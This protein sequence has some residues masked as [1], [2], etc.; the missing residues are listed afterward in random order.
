MRIAP[1]WQTLSAHAAR[2]CESRLADLIGADDARARDFSVRVGAL[3]GNFS[4]QRYDR[5]AHAA[6]VGMANEAGVPAALRALFEGEPV[7]R[8]EHRAALH[9]ALRSD[10][11]RSEAARSAQAQ[12]REA[13]ARMSALVAALESSDVTDVINIGIGGSDLGPRLAVDALGEFGTGRFRLH[14]LNNADGHPLQRLLRELDPA[15]TAVVLVSKSF[16]TQ[17]TLL[18]GNALKRWLRREDVLYAVTASPAKAEAFGVAAERILPMWDW[19]GGRY[20]LW[21]SVSLVCEIALTH[22]IFFRML[23]GAEEMDNHFRDTPFAQNLPAISAAVQMWN[24]EALGHGSYAMIPYSERLR[25][26][27]AWLQQLEM[28]SNGKRVMRDG[29]PLERSA[30][31]VTWGAARGVI[32]RSRQSLSPRALPQRGVL[33]GSPGRAA[34]RRRAGRATSARWTG[35]RSGIPGPVNHCVAIGFDLR[36]RAH[37]SG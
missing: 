4:R 11:G 3:Y 35:R 7:N 21:S 33:R 26:L 36:A 2:L 17:E 34:A 16:G 32:R 30:C 14:F 5:P 12:A 1:S 22:G 15:R 37:L 20:S 31:A 28:E 13:R 9:T 19:V 25:L 10:L 23:E 8:S 24:R 18:N 27:P 29:A 6:L